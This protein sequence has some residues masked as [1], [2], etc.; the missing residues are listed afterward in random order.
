MCLYICESSAS[1]QFWT[2]LKMVVDEAAQDDVGHELRVSER[3]A[4]QRRS[5]RPVLLHLLA[6]PILDGGPLVSLPVGSHY[7]IAHVVLRDGAEEGVEQLVTQLNCSAPSVP[8]EL[9][10]CGLSVVHS[11]P[12]SSVRVASSARSG[13][14]RAR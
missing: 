9:C 1:Q 2:P 8:T 3:G 5:A 12:S 13:T 6:E 11:C 4:C 10:H 7:R 14:L